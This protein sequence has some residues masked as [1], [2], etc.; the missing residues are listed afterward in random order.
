M[1][2]IIRMHP[3]RVNNQPSR[4]LTL[5]QPGLFGCII[6]HVS[7]PKITYQENIEMSFVLR[8]MVTLV[9]IAI[10]IT[11]IVL[12]VKSNHGKQMLL[13]LTIPLVLIGLIVGGIL[14]LFAVQEVDILDGNLNVRYGV[15]RSFPLEQ[16]ENL[17]P[18]SYS[19]A[20]TGGWGIRGITH[21]YFVPRHGPAIFFDF[22][23]GK[24]RKTYG[25]ATDDPSHLIALIKAGRLQEAPATRKSPAQP[26]EPFSPSPA[27]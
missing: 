17:R 16:I 15:L 9:I 4:M 22:D 12:P 23:N 26:T 13:T 6:V 21:T 25:I 11:A 10:I 27:L 2:E 7:A 5:S 8:T 24:R 14:S 18:G 20:T 19:F 3:G 1:G